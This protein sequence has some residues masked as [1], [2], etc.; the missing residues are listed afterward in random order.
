MLFW[1]QYFSTYE[2]LI[3]TILPDDNSDLLLQFILSK[4]FLSMIMIAIY[5]TSNRFFQKHKVL[6]DERVL[7]V[8]KSKYGSAVHLL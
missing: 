3:I 5:T 6:S 8:T 4:F 2:M 7:L 1:R